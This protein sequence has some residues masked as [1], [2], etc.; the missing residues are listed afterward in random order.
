M[1]VI[2]GKYRSR[3]LHSL[4]D[5]ALNPYE[6][7]SIHCYGSGPAVSQCALNGGSLIPF[8]CADQCRS[9]REAMRLHAGYLSRKPMAPLPLDEFI[10]TRVTNTGA[11]TLP[12]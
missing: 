6:L 11:H 7:D 8:G 10:S 5:T 2:A 12:R 3:P 1:R 4:R 9:M